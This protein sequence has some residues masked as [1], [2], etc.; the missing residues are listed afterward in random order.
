M[1]GLVYTLYCHTGCP[2]FKTYRKWMIILWPLW[3]NINYKTCCFSLCFT[4]STNLPFFAFK[5]IVTNI[6]QK[7]T[8]CS[9]NPP[10]FSFT[11]NL[12]HFV[13][14]PWLFLL[15]IYY[16][17]TQMNFIQP[18]LFKF[19]RLAQFLGLISIASVNL[20]KFNVIL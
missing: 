12:E 11:N 9:S 14:D 5:V 13:N 15:S 8:D 20:I 1:V 17:T 7:F 3:K 10:I 18:S 19:W 2:F 16:S 4:T 6:H